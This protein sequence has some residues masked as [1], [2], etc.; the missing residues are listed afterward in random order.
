[1]Q[2]INNINLLLTV[3][4]AKVQDRGISMVSEGPLPG[5]RLFTVSSHGGKSEGALCG[6]FYKTLIS[7]MSALPT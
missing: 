1:M 3:L 6:L 2:L 5:H 4:E 7:F